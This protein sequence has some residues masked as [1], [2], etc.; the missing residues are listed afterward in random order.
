MIKI[1][2]K[3]M[4][5]YVITCRVLSSLHFPF[6]LMSC[7]L[8]W[9]KPWSGPPNQLLKTG[10]VKVKK[11]G[12]L[13]SPWFESKNFFFDLAISAFF[14]KE[15]RFPI[16]NLDI[17]FLKTDN[18][19]SFHVFWWNTSCYFGQLFSIFIQWWLLTISRIFLCILFSETENQTEAK[20]RIYFSVLLLILAGRLRTFKIH[21]IFAKQTEN[22]RTFFTTNAKFKLKLSVFSL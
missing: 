5:V 10:W 14:W 18:L 9:K 11:L 4:L 6:V 13:L 3:L 21:L 2:F 22:A 20:R 8:S 12:S 17:L 15:K 19:S 1:S 7:D 16:R